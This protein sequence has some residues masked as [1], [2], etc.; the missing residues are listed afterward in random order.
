MEHERDFNLSFPLVN[1]LE[2]LWGQNDVQ[3]VD[4]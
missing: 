3:Y 4:V 1:L 2:L